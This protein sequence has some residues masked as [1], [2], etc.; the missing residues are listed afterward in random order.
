[1]GGGDQNS[2]PGFQPQ[3]DLIS[4]LSAIGGLGANIAGAF[5]NKV[6]VGDELSQFAAQNQRRSEKRQ[7]G[8][9]VTAEDAELAK[10]LVPSL[11]KVRDEAARGRVQ[12]FIDQ[13]RGKEGSAELERILDNQRSDDR[14]NKGLRSQIATENLQFAREMRIQSKQDLKEAVLPPD[15]QLRADLE[16]AFM[17]ISPEK[18]TSDS[19]ARAAIEEA[20]RSLKVSDKKRLR[21]FKREALELLGVGD[22]RSFVAKILADPKAE[23]LDPKQ[24]FK[25]FA[26]KHFS[27]EAGAAHESVR[28]RQLDAKDRQ[29]MANFISINARSSDPKIQQQIKEMKELILGK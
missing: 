5:T 8:E 19:S 7:Q 27:P 24:I 17:R 25:G 3:Q 2:K 4:T 1:M 26:N 28:A 29:D 20:A 10:K 22:K 9:F 23:Q 13:G 12:T 16:D 15:V 21:A 14:F 11:S 18:L 6:G